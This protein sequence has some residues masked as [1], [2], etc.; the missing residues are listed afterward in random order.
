MSI[1]YRWLAGGVGTLLAALGLASFWSFFAYQAP[2]SAAPLP[3]G[4]FVHYFAGT[5]GC[6]LIA[7][8]GALASGSL[9][10]DLARSLG[11]ATAVALVLLAAMRMVAWLMGDY[12]A[13]FGEL[14]RAE[15]AALLL[16]A[17]AFVWLRPKRERRIW[18]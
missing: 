8:G 1:A 16:L 17:L 7:W 14:P 15:A 3:G 10:G 6:A 9:R 18:S 4:P 13:A 11:T 2:G 12:Y 5:A